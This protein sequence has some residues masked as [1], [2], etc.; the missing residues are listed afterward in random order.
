M[1]RRT[2]L[3][4]AAAAALPL[5]AIAQS[6]KQRVLKFVPQANL[7]VMD[8]L[9]NSSS[10]VHQHSYLIYDNLFAV[11]ASFAPK[12][13]MVDSWSVSQDGLTYTFK[14]RPGLKF[15]DG[16]PVAAKDVVA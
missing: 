8:N 2:F 10:I 15:H 6:D 5:P 3:A 16:T 4:T 12:P 14:L 11:D 13:Q 1:K 7:G 9:V